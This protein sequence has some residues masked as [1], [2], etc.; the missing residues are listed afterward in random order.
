[1]RILVTNDDGLSS[2]GIVTLANSLA[3]DHEVHV[4][5]P[6]SQLSSIGA[7]RTYNRPIRV[8]RWSNGLYGDSVDVYA[9]D[10]T[11]SDAVFIG[12][13]MFKPDIVVSGVNLGENV[14]LESL[15]ISGT[16]GAVVQA[17]LMGV[18]GLAVSI[19]VPPS[20]KFTIPQIKG[21]YFRDAVSVVDGIVGYVEAK[22]WF[23]GI[24][25]L[26]IN[27]PSPGRWSGGYKVVMRLARV[28][29]KETLIE[30]KD[31]RGGNVYWRW[32]EELVQLDP[33]S[34]AYAFYKEGKLVVTP[35]ILNGLASSGIGGINDIE[36]ALSMTL[37][38]TNRWTR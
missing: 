1:M 24:D 8:W 26:S 30:S 4:I 29:F 36:N 7:A 27:V 34:D 20:G 13:N 32:G 11:P 31:P 37:N 33:D 9:T 15:F 28:L 12:I 3:G 5:A 38:S 2:P 16:I 35:I 21:D 19:E 17:S 14:G 22:G 6:E 25:A 18:P 10:G 23:N